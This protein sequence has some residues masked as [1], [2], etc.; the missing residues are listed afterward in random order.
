MYDR[1]TIMSTSSSYRRR[2]L[3]RAEIISRVDPQILAGLGST[4]ADALPDGPLEVSAVRDIAQAQ[5]VN[6]VQSAA[7]V[8]VERSEGTPLALRLHR[9]S[10]RA[11]VLWIHGGGMIL[12]S[13]AAEDPASAERAE[14]LGA[15]IVTPDYRLAPEHTY[16]AALEDCSAALR[17]TAARFDRVVVAGVSAGGGL[18]AALALR[19]RDAG[20]PVMAGLN[21]YAPMLDDRGRTASSSIYADTLVW[22]RR[23]NSLAWKAYLGTSAPDEWSAPA[24]ATDLSRLPPVYLDVGELDMFRDEGLAFASKIGAAGGRIE[25]H[26]DRGAVHGFDTRVPDASIS[27]AAKRRRLDALALMLR[28]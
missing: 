1:H 16:P 25:L 22:N 14:A 27:R 17:W 23:L 5:A 12:G 11:A 18:A 15:T 21:L 20:G 9:G 3:L 19:A 24:R 7:V 6:R 2:R 4:L 8:H 13:A 10:D 26:V 28:A